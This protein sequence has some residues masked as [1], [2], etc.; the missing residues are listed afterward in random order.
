[1]ALTG[2][3]AAQEKAAYALLVIEDNKEYSKNAQDAFGDHKVFFADTLEGA[4]I[5]L[6]EH[7]IDFIL[8]DVYF[9]SKS[10][11]EPKEQVPSILNI[12][13]ELST[14]L[15]FITNSDQN[16]LS[17]SSEEDAH[18][19]AMR[20][21][22]VSDI[23]KSQDNL[24]SWAKKDDDWGFSSFDLTLPTKYPEAVYARTKTPQIW[25]QAFRLVREITIA[26]KLPIPKTIPFRVPVERPLKLRR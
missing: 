5:I 4:F 25:T 24:A 17:I 26:A 6:Q 12:A 8:S 9:P 22:N 16:G 7:K 11:E 14:T 10:G 1:M 2:N 20:I 18:Y 13:F 21:L 23:R 19:V 15:A 3:L